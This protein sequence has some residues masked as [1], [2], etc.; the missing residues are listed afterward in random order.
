[1]K[2][3]LAGRLTDRATLLLLAEA[4]PATGYS[5]AEKGDGAFLYYDRNT[6]SELLDVDVLDSALRAIEAAQPTPDEV[7]VLRR[8]FTAK[9]GRG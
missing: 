8:F 9:R 2:E 4:L 5:S 3:W 6:Y 1:M 7:Q